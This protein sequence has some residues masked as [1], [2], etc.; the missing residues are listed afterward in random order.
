MR[1]V[2]PGVCSPKVALGAVVA[3]GVGAAAAATV[4]G[5]GVVGVAGGA[6]AWYRH[7]QV[8]RGDP[9]AR[10]S[11]LAP[12]RSWRGA[13]DE[14]RVECRQPVRDSYG[15][16]AL[17]HIVTPLSALSDKRAPRAFLATRLLST[18][19]RMTTQDRAA[20]N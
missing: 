5:I 20:C 13:Q 1:I 16:R 19:W 14:F 4:A 2:V 10:R 11:R 8:C 18:A 7:E 12:Y 9:A 3:T 17:D 15:V 6:A